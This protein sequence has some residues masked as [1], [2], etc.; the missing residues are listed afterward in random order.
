VPS[1]IRRSLLRGLRADP[2]QRHATMEDLLV[3]LE[4]DPVTR[5]RRV[6]AISLTAIFLVTTFAALYRR[7]ER[8]R[9][10][11]ER[12]VVIQLAQGRQAL[13]EA[14][15]LKTGLVLDRQRAF[16]AFD[17]GRSD[18][19]EAIWTEARAKAS[20]LDSTLK[21]AQGVLEAAVALD[22]TNDHAREA[23]GEAIY[24]RALLAESEMRRSDVAHFLEQLAR[25][26]A[27]G[28]FSARWTR[29]G[30]VE[31]QTTPAG[32]RLELERYD[33]PLDEADGHLTPVAVRT[34]F[35]S[36]PEPVLLPPGS[37]RVTI[38]KPGF[39]EA[40]LPFLLHRGETVSF[41]VRLLSAR[42]VPMDFVYVPRGRF[43]YGDADEDWRLGFLN[44][45]PVHERA[46]EPFLIKAHET[47]F[48]EWLEFLRT[49][50][51]SERL[52]RTPST[53]AIEG[54]IIVRGSGDLGW[55]LELNISGTKITARE[56]T[57]IVYPTR[58]VRVSQDWSRMPVMGI[59]PKDMQ[60]YLDWLS[61]TGRVPG[62]RFCDEVEWERAARGADGRAY[63]GSLVRLTGDDA[64]IDVTYGRV[65]GSYGPDE[66][67]SHPASRSPFGIDDLAGNAWEVVQP[68]DGGGG[69]L[70]RGGS[71]YHAST[72]A[73]STNRE[74]IEQATRSYH[75][76]LR[77]CAAV[78]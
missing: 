15:R 61:Q 67:G 17:A 10:E 36:S 35:A 41:D 34:P 27:G 48:G 55:L 30:S 26:D 13:T 21:R 49:L 5:L 29:P 65:R 2:A 1:W 45:S 47:T 16:A 25:I 8:R 78:K 51:A 70:I 59:S 19:G 32:A 22:Q 46:T 60:R 57:P 77:V 42:D 56:K 38:R 24:E 3:A 73:R 69:Y 39:A 66:V 52:L 54:A 12:R 31:I 40:R 6:A 53:V 74:W 33:L 62:A 7:S 28:R 44:A 4:A 20:K 18:E 23:L 14:E 9:V 43:L 63:P 50:T 71:Y 58:R 68:R 72:S 37:Y 11:F 76:G 75:L 64:N